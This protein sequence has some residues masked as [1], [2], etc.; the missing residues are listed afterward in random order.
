M[1]KKMLGFFKRYGIWMGAVLVTL[2]VLLTTL[3]VLHYLRLDGPYYWFLLIYWGD[4]L[5]DSLFTQPA[6]MIVVLSRILIA[7]ISFCN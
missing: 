4:I 2:E 6:T 3:E 5:V 1:T 7:I